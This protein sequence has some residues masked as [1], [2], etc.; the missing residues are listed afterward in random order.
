MNCDAVRELMLVCDPEDLHVG[1]ASELAAHL[2][3]CP[4]CGQIASRI[5]AGQQALDDAL[6]ALGP[7]SP[8]DE[9]SA[10]IRASSHRWATRR[11]RALPLAAAAG[12]IAMLFGRALLDRPASDA[13]APGPSARAAIG[14][15]D[16][17]VLRA[18]E[19]GQMVV[20][21]T[22]DP[23]VTVVWFYQER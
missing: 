2:R 17:L 6:A 16:R 7:R 4:A 21:E 5:L 12:L 10:G 15:A 18:P 3:D 8:G 19:E 13:P 23:S 1:G 14:P 20:F 22:S 11:W 9:A